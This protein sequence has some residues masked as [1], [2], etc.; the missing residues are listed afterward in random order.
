MVGLDSGFG[1]KGVSILSQTET[2]GL[3]SMITE[4]LFTDQFKELSASDIAL[5]TD[6]GKIDAVTGAT[7]SSRAVVN[8]VKEKMVEIIDSFEK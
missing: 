7:I 4:S 3:G 1:I 2:P 8:A 6:G 5:K